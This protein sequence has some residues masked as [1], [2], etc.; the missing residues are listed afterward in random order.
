MPAQ[1]AVAFQIPETLLRVKPA[2]CSF[3]VTWR[4]AQQVV[5]IVQERVMY[6]YPVQQQCVHYGVYDV[7][8]ARIYVS[9]KA[10]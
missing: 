4:L 5:L 7:C 10:P 3:A 2:C 9:P 8:I 6:H 1:M